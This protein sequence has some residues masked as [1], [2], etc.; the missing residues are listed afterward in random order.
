MGRIVILST[1]ISFAISVLVM[2]LMG[3]LGLGAQVLGVEQ[4]EPLKI[5]IVDMQKI[6]NEVAK[7]LSKLGDQ[8][9]LDRFQKI[10]KDASESLKKDG[11]VVLSRGTVLAYPENH[12][13]VY[14]ATDDI[15]AK[16]NKE[17]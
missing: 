6:T 17:L 7:D 13:Y 11:Y 1:S 14:D 4:H 8:S 12:Y 16:L 15:L 10:I 2:F 9:G 5:A 3:Y